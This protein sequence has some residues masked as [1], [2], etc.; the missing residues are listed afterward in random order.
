MTVFF[1]LLKW[2][3]FSSQV[4]LPVISSECN[5]VI[6]GFSPVENGAPFHRRMPKPV[7]ELKHYMDHTDLEMLNKKYI[8]YFYENCRFMEMRGCPGL[9]TFAEK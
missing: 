7:Y 5:S 1:S 3:A 6:P 8:V 9:P 2:G 4:N